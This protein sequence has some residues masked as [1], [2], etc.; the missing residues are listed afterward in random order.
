VNALE[1]HSQLYL[2]TQRTVMRSAAIK[3]TDVSFIDHRWKIGVAPAIQRTLAI[4]APGIAITMKP[5]RKC[6]AD[7]L[8]WNP[9]FHSPMKIKL[10]RQEEDITIGTGRMTARGRT[11]CLRP[12]IASVKYRAIVLLIKLLK[13]QRRLVIVIPCSFLNVGGLFR[14]PLIG[15]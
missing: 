11:A 10:S 4:D 7:L 12:T 13:I 5:V 9:R 2:G 8:E 6:F 15:A 1:M 3:I 14:V